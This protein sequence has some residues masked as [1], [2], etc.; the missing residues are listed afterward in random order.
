MTLKHLLCWAAGV[1]LCATA[2]G[3]APAGAQTSD[4]PSPPPITDFANFPLGLGIV[5]AT[6]TSQGASAVVNPR[7]SVD[8]GPEV[9]D[10]RR[11]NLL[12]PAQAVV[13]RWDGFAAGCE[14]IGVALSR[15]SSGATVFDPTIDQVLDRTAY[16]GPEAGAIPCASPFQLTL[17]LD[18][19]PSDPSIP[20]YQVDASLGPPL[21]VV[22]PSGSF[23]GHGQPFNML[24]SAWNG[25]TEPC[26]VSNTTLPPTTLPPTTLPPTTLPPPTA[27]S[28]PAVVPTTTSVPAST[29]TTVQAAST[30]QPCPPGMTM[31]AAGCVQV[32]GAQATIPV[33]GTSSGT[34]G[35]TGAALVGLGA[36]AMLVAGTVSRWAQRRSLPLP[37]ESTTGRTGRR[38]RSTSER[39]MP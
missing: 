34:T 25:G 26:L 33:T 18:A 36:V 29:V 37:I 30:T 14:Q 24:I 8:G 17:F 35:A 1:L 22:G 12:P 2:F 5:P 11:L 7:F 32:A 39:S 6:C 9:S 27:T 20:C 10:L 21:A 15:K 31:S 23:Y 28:A 13:M 3:V 19:R 16:C 38:V 4:D